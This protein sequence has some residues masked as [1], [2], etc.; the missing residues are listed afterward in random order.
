M[1]ALDR[2]IGLGPEQD[3]PRLIIVHAFAPWLASS[4]E[5][6]SVISP[7]AA[8]ILRHMKHSTNLP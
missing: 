1:R 5:Q 3:S 4:A 2:L 6:G 7:D 8:D